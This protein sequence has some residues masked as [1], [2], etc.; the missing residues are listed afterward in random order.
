MSLSAVILALSLSNS[1]ELLAIV[2]TLLTHLTALEMPHDVHYY[3]NR[4]EGARLKSLIMGN[5]KKT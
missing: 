3:S 5:T 2:L 1:F 4:K